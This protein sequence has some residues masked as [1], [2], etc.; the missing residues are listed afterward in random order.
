MKVEPLG[1]FV[2]IMPVELEEKTEGG[3]YLPDTA[4]D[5]HIAQEGK[6]IEAGPDCKKLKA[7]D[8]ILLPKFKGT[9]IV[10]EGKKYVFIEEKDILG[11]ITD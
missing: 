4:K 10:L 6:V 8:Q 11:R 9:P 5:K 3:I 1:E 7:D 2:F